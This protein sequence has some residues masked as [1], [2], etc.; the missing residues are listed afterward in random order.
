MTCRNNV[1]DR[2]FV[3]LPRV[4]GLTSAGRSVSLPGQKRQVIAEVVKCDPFDIPSWAF[5]A[6]NPVVFVEGSKEFIEDCPF[7]PGGRERPSPSARCPTSVL[8]C[9][10]GSSKEEIDLDAPGARFEHRVGGGG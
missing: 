7:F 1:P 9:R 2:R 6:G 5:S 10:S 3:A 4:S 8:P